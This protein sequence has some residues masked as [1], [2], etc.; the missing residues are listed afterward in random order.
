MPTYRAYFQGPDGHFIDR[1][2]I[3]AADDEK[4]I[5][6]VCQFAD[7]RPIEVWQLGRM[8]TKIDPAQG[9][10]GNLFKLFRKR[11]PGKGRP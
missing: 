8:V 9:M 7:G 3:V 1:R 11:E 2:E 10:P 5:A 6:Q 4:A